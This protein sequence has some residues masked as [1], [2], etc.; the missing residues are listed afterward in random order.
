MINVGLGVCDEDMVEI[1]TLVPELRGPMSEEDVETINPIMVVVDEELKLRR[2][3]D[4]K[5]SDLV[6][7]VW[8]VLDGSRRTAG[9]VRQLEVTSREIDDFLKTHP[10]C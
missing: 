5:K 3:G 4:F 9:C 1:D 6:N 10:K 2:K 7:E 8:L